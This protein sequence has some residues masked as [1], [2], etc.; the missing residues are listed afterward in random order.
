[1]G[2]ADVVPGVSGGTIAFI[3]GIYE[4][5]LDSIN[6]INLPALRLLF[7]RKFADFWAHINGNFLV[8]LFSGIFLSLFSLAS[9][10]SYLMN[11]EPLALWSFFF[12]LIFISSILVFKR[13]HHWS[14]GSVAGAI[15]GGIVGYYFT[16]FSP[17]ET[18]NGLVY[19][20]FSGAIAIS[21]MILP[22]I[23]GSY[24]LLILGKYEFII[25]AV[26]EMKISIIIV[27]ALGC[28]VGLLSFSRLISWILKKYHNIAIAILAGFMLGSL[29]KIWPWKEVLEY[30]INSHGEQ[31]PFIDKSMLPH[32][33]LELTGNDPHF[34]EA[35]LF[36]VLGII[37]ILGIERIAS[38]ISR[39]RA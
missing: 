10:I 22:G 7:N 3:S 31:V 6:S 35:L 27:F 28:A 19:V 23:S 24:I 15:I 1:M 20:F 2:G 26:K 33:Y 34:L 25:D 8:T 13:I 18:N 32:K 12:G 9:V 4:E 11:N 17:I 5:L 14:V 39:A 21:A 37:L 36:A 30:R 16:M 38:M 29:N